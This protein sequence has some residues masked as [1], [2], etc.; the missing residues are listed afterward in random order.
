MRSP[1]V[2]TE[3]D[4]V[5]RDGREIVISVAIGEQHSVPVESGETDVGYYVEVE[6][7]MKRRSQVGTDSFMAM[8]FSIHLVR[9][10]LVIFV[11][12]GG[13]V[14]FRGSRCPI[15]LQSPSFES[16]GGL[17]RSEHL[18]PDPPPR[19]NSG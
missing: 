12:H 16:V 13:S 5:T 9:K 6:P 1:V 3:F 7:L 19:K 8:C 10:A 2:Q 4:A 14:F 18:A 17:I 15:D 11:A